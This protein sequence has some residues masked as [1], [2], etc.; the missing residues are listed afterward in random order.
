MMQ[1]VMSKANK[2]YLQLNKMT[3]FRPF[4]FVF[5]VFN[6]TAL[7]IQGQEIEKNYLIGDRVYNSLEEATPNEFF[8]ELIQRIVFDEIN[9]LLEKKGLDPKTENDILKNAALDQAGYMA[10]IEDDE[11]LRKEK[12]KE[13]TGDRISFY[14]GSKQGDELSGKT[15][16]SKGK[17]PYTYAKIADDIVFRWFAS[18]KKAALIENIGYNLV[19]IGA[20]LDS[21]E[22]RIY[23]SLVLGNYK[24]FNE[25]IAYKDQL[26][27]PYSEKTY[28]LTEANPLNCKKVFRQE[29]LND[30][31]KNLYVENNIIYFETDDIRPIK[32]LIRKKKDGLA[33]D[34]IQKNQYACSGPNIVDHNQANQGILTKRLYTKKLFKN[35]LADL[36]ENKRAFKTQLGVLPE[37]LNDSYELGLVIIQNKSYCTTVP[38]SFIIEANGQYKKKL[39]ILADTVTIN[40]KFNYKPVADTMS[41]TFRVP[42]ENKKFTYQASD[43]EP[44]LKLLNEPAFTIINLKITAFSSIEGTDKE[45]KML[46]QKRAESIVKALEQR[47]HDLIQAEIITD[48]NWEDFNRDIQSTNHNVLASMNLE[49]AQAYIRDYN[50][51]KDLEPILANHRY[52]RID[53]KVTYDISGENEQPFVVKKFNKAIAEDDRIMA[54]SIQKYIIKQVLNYKYKASILAELEIPDD[55]DFAGMQM[56]KIWLQHLTKQIGTEDFQEKVHALYQLNPENEY[57]AFNDVFLNVSQTPFNDLNDVDILQTRIDR[58]YYTPLKKSTVDALNIKLQFKLI[59]YIDSIGDNADRKEASV[60]RIKDI[61]DIKGESM[62]NSLKLAEL[63]IEN[64]DFAFALKTLAPWVTNYN[65]NENL[66]FTYASLCSQFEEQMHTQRFNYA[67][68]RAQEMNNTR[69]CE[70]LNGTYFSLKIFENQEI[71][72]AY[73][74]HCETKE[75]MASDE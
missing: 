31:Q 30:F 47:Q 43:I 63:F 4:T 8:E 15:N 45:N 73:C 18:S 38:Q 16:I 19:G 41:L 2:L 6:L 49:E 26:E 58:L 48:Y 66:I 23:V 42:F 22:R 44:F 72:Q 71:K 55:K 13:T 56:N 36:S 54:L 1:K 67:M 28:G 12:D 39:S 64:K 7:S 32:R 25:G 3:F 14:G 20:K 68:Q 27:L 57:L 46:Q 17:I 74:K 21:K 11:L 24:S 52:A 33:V 10:Q 29:N 37:N 50:L 53:M 59:N 34:I 70:L 35:N 51:N 69:F 5:F 60:E 40:S 9:I 62:Q 61:V 75:K 65:A